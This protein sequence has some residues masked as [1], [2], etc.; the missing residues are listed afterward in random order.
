MGLFI[1]AILIIIAGIVLL[2]NPALVPAKGNRARIGAVIAI[3][4]GVTG[5]ISSSVTVIDAGE[6]G[7]V[8]VLGQVENKSLE[9]G[10]HLVPPY[11][12]IVKYP[13]RIREYT[14]VGSDAVNAKANNGLS[15]T[16][17]ATILYYVDPTMSGMVYRKV[18]PSIEILESGILTP[19]LRTIIRDIVSEYS[20]DEIYSTKRVEV[21]NK[22]EKTMREQVSNKGVII[23]KFLI[24]NIDLP[25]EIDRAIQNKLAAQQE[26][27]AMEYKK[28]KAQQEA[29]IKIIE[30]KGLAEAQQ[31][32]NSTLSPNYLQHEAIQAYKE[33][34]TSQNSTFVILPTSP[35][36]SGMPLILNGVK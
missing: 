27:E 32:I 24:R 21:A 2:V 14:L 20:A 6:V 36:S 19:T 16:I 31:I 8:I 23:D 18:A 35:N 4:V 22:I 30:A 7:V 34:A 10:V 9:S 5:L 17:D 1:F 29:E 28:S 12:N 3:V 26:A 13:T 33:L 15:I 11:A 25:E